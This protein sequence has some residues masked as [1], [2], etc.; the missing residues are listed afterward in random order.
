[1]NGN[2][3]WSANAPASAG[4]VS[5]LEEA[6]LGHLES[7]KRADS[8]LVNQGANEKNTC[9]KLGVFEIKITDAV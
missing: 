2:N 3:W 8:A 9:R 1:M 4:C 7:V 5:R 6:N